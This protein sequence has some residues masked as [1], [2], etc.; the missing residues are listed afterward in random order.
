MVTT[1]VGNV[2]VVDREKPIYGPAETNYDTWLRYGRKIQRGKI[3]W[4]VQLNIR[5]IFGSKDLIPVAT[6]PDGTIASARIPQP[7]R[8]TLTNSFDF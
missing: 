3:Y 2:W 8:W 7:N 1:S 5:D 6:Q 4:S